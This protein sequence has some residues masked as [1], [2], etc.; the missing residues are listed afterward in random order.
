ML[1]TLRRAWTT[2]HDF[3]GVL[4]CAFFPC[5]MKQRVSLRILKMC[6]G[7]KPRKHIGLCVTEVI[8]VTYKEV[9]KKKKTLIMLCEDSGM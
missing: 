6:A 7:I 1:R 8:C 4:T 3:F 9:G 5:W 2:F